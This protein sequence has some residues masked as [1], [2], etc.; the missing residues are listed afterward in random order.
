M[1][2]EVPDFVGLP[3]I[4]PFSASVKPSGRFPDFIDHVIAAVP[5]ALRATLYDFPARPYV[6]LFVVMLAGMPTK[7]LRVFVLLP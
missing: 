5:L 4:L 3:E 7:S 1:K 2:V 6:M